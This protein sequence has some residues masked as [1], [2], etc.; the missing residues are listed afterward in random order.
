MSSIYSLSTSWHGASALSPE[1]LITRTTAMGFDRIELGFHLSMEMA[2]AYVAAAQRGVLRI[3]SVHNVCPV[4][5]GFTP[6]TFFPDHFSLASCVQE[7]RLRAVE[8]ASGTLRLAQR[9][10]ARVMVLHAGRVEI[11]DRMRQLRS[12]ADAGN[13]RSDEYERIL[14]EMRRERE[15]AKQPHMKALK[16][17]LEALVPLAERWDVIIGLETRYY[18]RELPNTEEFAELFAHFKG[19]AHV[20]YWH[21]MGHA[22]VM[23]YL[24][25]SGP[26]DFLERF[27]GLLC[28]IHFHDVRGSQDHRLPGQGSVDFSLFKPYLRP[29][30]IRVLEVHPPVSDQ[31]LAQARQFLEQIEFN[32]AE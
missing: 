21:D 29:E 22:L 9:A 20:K 26:G 27:A 11:P 13:R 19:T 2:D 6:G 4:P 7:E 1:E 24:G 30:V 12:V 18:Y 23:E 15:S 16:T 25:L 3:S 14:V 5:P 17:S 10:G 8:L 31:E 28:G 32:L